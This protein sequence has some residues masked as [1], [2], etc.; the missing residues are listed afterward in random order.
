[1]KFLAS[2]QAVS[3]YRTKNKNFQITFFSKSNLKI[4]CLNL[5]RALFYPNIVKQ[6]EPYFVK[7]CC[8]MRLFVE[9]KEIRGLQFCSFENEKKI[10]W[11]KNQIFSFVFL[12]NK[13]S[14]TQFW[15]YRGLK[16]SESVL[17]DFIFKKGEIM[18][19]FYNSSK[20]K[21]RRKNDYY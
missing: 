12:P 4:N 15:L 11:N 3:R 16:R 7:F 9:K 13:N 5:I 19:T 8:M 1:M 21:K 6:S 10:Y 17:V 14:M 20:R 2:N 18:R